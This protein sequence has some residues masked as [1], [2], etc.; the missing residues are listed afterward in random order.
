MGFMEKMRYHTESHDEELDFIFN[1]E[2]DVTKNISESTKQSDNNFFRGLKIYK[3]L[4]R[5][6]IAMLLREKVQKNFT[7]IL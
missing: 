3:R 6:K 1:Q 4:L 7:N 2:L 5:R